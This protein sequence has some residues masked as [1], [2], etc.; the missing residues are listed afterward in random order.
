MTRLIDSPLPLSVPPSGLISEAKMRGSRTNGAGTS[1]LI[2]SGI[3]RSWRRSFPL[4]HHRDTISQTEEEEDL[5][6][7][8]TLC[9]LRHL[10]YNKVAMR[11]VFN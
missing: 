5:P 11:K 7:S 2:R 4:S 6:F 3:E 1:I 9:D 8:E 10:T